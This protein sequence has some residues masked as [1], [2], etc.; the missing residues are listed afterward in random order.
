E[1]IDWLGDSLAHLVRT[2]TAPGEIAVLSRTR[3]AG[4]VRRPVRPAHMHIRPYC[5]T[6][7]PGEAL[8]K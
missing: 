1:E 4:G 7:W 2:G 3:R 8:V 6:T 5:V